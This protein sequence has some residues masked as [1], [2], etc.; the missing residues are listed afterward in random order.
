MSP[1]QENTNELTPF[2]SPLTATAFAVGTSLGW[3]SLVVTSNTYLKKAGPC[4]SVLGIV[5]GAVIMLL[6]CRSYHY[7]SNRLSDSSDVYSY[8]KNLF[9]YDRAFIVSWFVFLLYFAIFLANATAVPLFV[10]YIFGD[11]FRFGYLYTIFDYDVYTGEILLTVAVVGLSLLLLT[12]S[13][14][15]ATGLMVGLVAVFTLGITVCFAVAIFRNISGNTGFNPGFV[16]G[17]A[18]VKQIAGIACISPWAFVGFEG[19]THSSPEFKFP[20]T[21][22]F[23][24]LATS[25]VISTALYIFVTLLSVT[26][27]PPR[28]SN[29]LEY[30]NDLDNLSG[31][32]AIPAFYAAG[33][34]LGNA[35]LIILICSLFALVVTSLIA[36][37]WALSRLIKAAGQDSIFSEKFTKLNKKGVPANAIL[38]VAGISFF[39]IFLGRSAIG[40]IVDVTTLIATLLYGFVAASAM[41]CAKTNGD[42]KDYFIGLAVL[43][44]MVLFGTI[45]ILPGLFSESMEPE[46]YLL[47]ILWLILGMVFFHRVITKDHAR[48]FGKAIIVWLVLISMIIV[49]GIIWMERVEKSVAANIFTEINNYHDGIAP[50]SAL[51]MSESEYLAILDRRLDTTSI[52]S[53]FVVLGLVAISIGGFVS[54]YFSMRKYENLLEK[55]VAAKTEHIIKMQNDLVIGMATMVESHD[56]STGG[57]IKRT[58]DVV[59]ILV[60]E[61]KKDKRFSMPDDFYDN[62]IK[63]APMHDLGKI[64]VDDAILR[65]P[66]RFTPEEY[67]IMKSHAKEGARIVKEITKNIDD[68]GL[69]SIAENMAHYHHE[70]VNGS[71]YPEKLK[72]DEIPLEARIMA[73]ADVYDTLVSKRVYKEKMGFD[74]ADKIIVSGMGTQ[75]DAD[76]LPCYEAARPKLEAYYKSVQD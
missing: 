50:Q 60:D 58:S 73:I 8:A 62:V 51:N 22:I 44:V 49:M 71:G 39:M 11:F 32:E 14:R 26:A 65:K 2:I 23:K 29:W 40:W 47:F 9:G 68:S 25:V 18:P 70:W 46:T 3:G 55:D 31:F 64:A 6:I 59:Q 7:I 48:H 66:G 63:A 33:R 38:L 34:H 15:A 12:K 42:R 5:I 35:G 24:I 52:I 16:P 17:S 30:I 1:S 20:K 61:I 37:M 28:Y 74:E 4:G 43:I 19:V 10:R 57:H 21:K 69:S 72:G 45:M 41:K 56:N 53:T 27:Y 13:K 75:F 36:N 67:E 54:N 76:L